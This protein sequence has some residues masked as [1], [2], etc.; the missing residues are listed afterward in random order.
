MTTRKAVIKERC[1]CPRCGSVFVL[2]KELVYHENILMWTYPGGFHCPV[3]GCQNKDIG[4]VIAYTY[5]YNENRRIADMC[6]A[7]M[8]RDAMPEFDLHFKQAS[9]LKEEVK[10]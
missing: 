6:N 1:Y 9:L 4:V 7:N 2:D 10:A 8:V 5:V 3:K